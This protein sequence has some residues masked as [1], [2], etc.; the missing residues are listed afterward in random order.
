M[1]F[2]I[3]S[4]ATQLPEALYVSQIELLF[5]ILWNIY[6]GRRSGRLLGVACQSVRVTPHWAVCHLFLRSDALLWEN[7]I[8]FMHPQASVGLCCFL[9]FHRRF[10][11]RSFFRYLKCKG[12]NSYSVSACCKKIFL[13]F[14]KH[15]FCISV[16]QLKL[17]SSLST[18][19]EVGRWSL[20]L[21]PK[22]MG[23][24]WWWSSWREQSRSWQAGE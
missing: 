8:A 15:V 20:T 10:Q 23:L 22:K 14:M 3:Y 24:G 13:G 1:C 17:K 11:Y 7:L 18:Y 6:S 19:Q 21:E 12:T 16:S 2:R 4:V 5:S 9:L